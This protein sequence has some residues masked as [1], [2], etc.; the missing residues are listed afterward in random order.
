ML[1]KLPHRQFV[2]TLLKLLRVYFKHDRNLFA[3]ISKIIFSI[4]VY[5][6]IAIIKKRLNLQLSFYTISQIFSVPAF[7]HMP[8]IQ[9]LTDSNFTNQMTN[10]YNQ[11]VLFDL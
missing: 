7:E 5:V 8:I 4:S 11:L 3:D 1:L 2:F 6:L 9:V 10:S